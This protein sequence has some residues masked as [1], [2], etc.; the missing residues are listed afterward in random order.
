MLTAPEPVPFDRTATRPAYTDLPQH[1]RAR[2]EHHLGGTV[3]TVQIAG[4][5]F[6]SGFAARITTEGG[7]AAFVKA[8]GPHTPVY[9]DHYGTE[10]RSSPHSPTGSPHRSSSS[11]TTTPN[12]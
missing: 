1:V 5:G 12:G 2:I 10:R 6:T 7:T 11:S 8:A 9:I 3:R 4:G